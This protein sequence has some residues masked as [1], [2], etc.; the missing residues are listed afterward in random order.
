MKRWD[1]LQFNNLVSVGEKSDEF[2][3]G[4]M[5]AADEFIEAV[6]NSKNGYYWSPLLDVSKDCQDGYRAAH[7][8]RDQIQSVFIGR[9]INV[10]P[11]SVVYHGDGKYSISKQR[12]ATE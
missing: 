4:Y 9:N 1:W 3:K 6:V 8:D 12:H 11:D 7:L 2:K 10:D 5:R